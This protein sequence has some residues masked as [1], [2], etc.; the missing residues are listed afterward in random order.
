[1]K[2]KTFTLLLTL[3]LMGIF[4][5]Q[6]DNYYSRQAQSYMRDAEYYNRQAMPRRATAIC[7]RPERP[8]PRPSA[9]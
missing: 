2:T 5:A 3:L 1:M 4:T 6:A 8:A 9:R 7:A